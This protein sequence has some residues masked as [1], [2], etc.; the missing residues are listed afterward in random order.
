MIALFALVAFAAP[1]H[2]EPQAGVEAV[3]SGIA[4]SADGRLVATCDTDG[5][6]L[7]DLASGQRLRRVDLPWRPLRVVWQSA[8]VVAVELDRGPLL[9]D[10]RDGTVSAASAPLAPPPTRPNVAWPEGSEAWA[11]SPDGSR[12]AVSTGQGTEVWTVDPWARVWREFDDSANA[13]AFTPDG[14]HLL[15]A[16]AFG[17]EVWN[18]AEGG[19][20]AGLRRRGL[21][22]PGAI[23]FSPDG[24]WLAF[25]FPRLA[26]PI[27][28]LDLS[29]GDWVDLPALE[30]APSEL[31][32]ASDSRGF[33]VTTPQRLWHVTVDGRIPR[34]APLA[35]PTGQTLAVSPTGKHLAIRRGRFVHVLDAST[36][37]RIG[38]A[39]GHRSPH[40]SIGHVEFA[41][42]GETLFTRTRAE[43]AR[44]DVATLRPRWLTAIRTHKA[45][46]HVLDDGTVALR[47]VAREIWLDG[48]TGEERQRF[49]D[50]GPLAG[51]GRPWLAMWAYA[52]D[53]IRPPRMRPPLPI[54]VWRDGNR[55]ALGTAG[56]PY[57]GLP[58]W[59]GDLDVTA[60]A[61]DDR[62]VVT[63]IDGGVVKVWDTRTGEARITFGFVADPDGRPRPV[64]WTPDAQ[65]DAPEGFGSEALAFSRGGVRVEPTDPEVRALRSPGL[66]LREW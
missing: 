54:P 31:V 38:P 3:R 36:G 56:G 16:E 33:F 42:D 62:R 29:G 43:V 24:R 47:M 13:M 52:G 53:Q 57:I 25:T 28:L 17:V 58:L 2:L 44:W 15:V 14:K 26:S 7:W 5:L 49:P 10:V 39:L 35:G 27:A 55:V 66:L 4:V 11:P 32:W 41:P 30:E 40:D 6:S 34:V 1:L 51:D 37:E 50:A 22:V 18:V 48:A 65:W 20:E 45:R 63:S 61:P 23:A 19:R 12:I 21:L 60:L 46:I 8:H 64:A 59:P 9:V